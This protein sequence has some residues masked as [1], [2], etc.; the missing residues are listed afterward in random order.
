MCAKE[1]QESCTAGKRQLKEKKYGKDSHC[2]KGINMHKLG[3]AFV[4]EVLKVREG[5]SREDGLGKGLE[6]LARVRGWDEASGV[7]RRQKLLAYDTEIKL[8]RALVQ[9]NNILQIPKSY[10]PRTKP[11]FEKDDGTTEGGWWYRPTEVVNCKKCI[12]CYNFRAE[13]EFDLKQWQSKSGSCCHECKGKDDVKRR[14]RINRAEE[15]A[16]TRT[17]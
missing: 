3:E 10:Y 12:G 6:F 4:G 16:E 5:K 8:C 7:R 1:F 11:I 13:D 14:R 9:T 2:R 15:A 17:R